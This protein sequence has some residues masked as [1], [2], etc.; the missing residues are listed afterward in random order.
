MV[1]TTCRF[2][3]SVRTVPLPAFMPAALPYYAQRSARAQFLR[4]LVWFSA[5]RFA[6]HHQFALRLPFTRTCHHCVAARLVA[7]PRSFRPATTCTQFCHLC[8]HCA[9]YFPTTLPVLRRAFCAH[10]ALVCSRAAR[11]CGSAAHLPHRVLLHTTHTALPTTPLFSTT[12]TP[13]RRAA[14]TPHRC[15]LLVPWFVGSYHHHR[16][17]APRAYACRLCRSPL[18]HYS[19]TGWFLRVCAVHTLPF[20]YARRARARYRA[21][22]R[23]VYALRWFGYGVPARAR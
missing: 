11:T 3:G 1:I 22:P 15:H 13:R 23:A 18:Y 7:V 14:C 6:K 21:A 20:L 16:F 12:Y 4:F 9:T 17:F 8:H 5:Q 19:F 2:F 10:A